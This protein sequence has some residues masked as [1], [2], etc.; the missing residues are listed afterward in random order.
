MEAANLS[1]TSDILM[2]GFSDLPHLQAPLFSMFLLLYLLT[3]SGNLLIVAT[4]SSNSQLHTPM[5]FFVSM[6]S[7]IDISYTSV[8]LPPMLANFFLKDSHVSLTKCLLQMNFFLGIA[9]AEVVLLTV[10]AYDR[11]VA[12]CNPLHYSSIMNLAVCIRL[13][14]GSWLIGLMLALPFTV[15]V[16]GFSY[17]GSRTINHFFCDVTAL[18]KITCTSTHTIEIVIYAIGASLTLGSFI[19]IIISYVNIV[20][21]IIKI[22]AK[23]G[24]WKAF[25]T[26]TSHLTVVLVFYGSLCATYIRPKSAMGDSKISSLTYIIISPLCNPIIYS[27]RNTD[28]KNALRPK[29]NKLST[30]GM[31]NN[32][33]KQ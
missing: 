23:A 13:A 26:C 22:K 28:F 33:I 2:V 3:L 8:V 32:T 27:M 4:V 25:L 1:S 29:N 12:I 5:Y 7:L 16:S 17:C 20:S 10:M 30:I 9:A 6:L 14:V 19:L 18:M 24:R 31:N 11:Y 15:A 21:S